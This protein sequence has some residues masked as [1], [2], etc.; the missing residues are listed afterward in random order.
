MGATW[1][2]GSDETP[3]S[4]LDAVIILAPV[5]TLVP[6][7][8]AMLS[9][10]GQ[11]V[12]GGIHMSDIPAFPYDILWRERQIVSVA[13]LARDDAREFFDLA[14]RVPVR[15]HVKPCTL[16]DANKALDDLRAGRLEGAAGLTIE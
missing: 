16:G 4:E 14:A 12:C 11:V 1:A 13:N 6:A 9:K 10:G 5:G 3:F 2:G 15:T 7:A 8:L